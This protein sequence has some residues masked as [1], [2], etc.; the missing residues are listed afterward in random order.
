MISGRVW[1]NQ[2]D[3]RETGDD[4]IPDYVVDDPWE[5]PASIYAETWGYRSWQKRVPLDD[6]IHEQILRLVKVV[7]RG[8]NYILNIGPKGDGSVVDYEANV[9]RGA[10]HG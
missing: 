7:S 3:F 8:G 5:S 6:K 10:G 1:N 4:E 9:L 2:G